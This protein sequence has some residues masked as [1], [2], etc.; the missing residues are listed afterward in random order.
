M[1]DVL[2][3]DQTTVTRLMEMFA[4]AFSSL[5]TLLA[6]GDD[7]TDLTTIENDFPMD[8]EHDLALTAIETCFQLM[9]HAAH[10]SESQDDLHTVMSTTVSLLS[11]GCFTGYNVDQQ[12]KKSAKRQNQNRTL[13]CEIVTRLCNVLGDCFT[14]GFGTLENLPACIVSCKFIM[15]SETVAKLWCKTIYAMAALH[16]EATRNIGDVDSLILLVAKSI[17]RIFKRAF[18]KDSV[19]RT[20]IYKVLTASLLE[21]ASLLSNKDCN[22]LFEEITRNCLTCKYRQDVEHEEII[23]DFLLKFRSHQYLFDHVMEEAW[24]LAQS[25]E[26]TEVQHLCCNL[27]SQ[28]LELSG[29]V[30]QEF[31]KDVMAWISQ[32]AEDSNLRDLFAKISV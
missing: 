14:L 28:G 21:S 12:I 22:E 26:D 4:R 18:R 10:L 23:L 30:F 6:D 27:I 20:K 25:T 3:E 15:F 2:L 17:N 7:N 13:L 19:M 5:E 9:I 24:S 32:T 31:K 16:A 8:A 1:R 11:H 29:S